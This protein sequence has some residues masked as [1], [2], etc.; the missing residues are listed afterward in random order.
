MCVGLVVIA[1][2]GLLAFVLFVVARAL[3]A[4]ALR[5]G[6]RSRP[7][8]EPALAS[9]AAAGWGRRILV[10]L[11][12]PLTVSGFATALC[13]MGMLVE[14]KAQI[15]GVIL[16]DGA[17]PGSPAEQAGLRRNDRIVGIDGA[18]PQ[19]YGDV[20]A[21]VRAHP[22]RPVDL[23]IERAGKRMRVAVQAGAA[24]TRFAGRIGVT[25]MPEFRPM[26]L[27]EAARSGLA[28]PIEVW[29]DT[30]E[31]ALAPPER[32]R[33]DLRGPIGIVEATKHTAG[34]ISGR[35]LTAKGMKLSTDTVPTVLLASLAMLL[36]GGRRRE[37]PPTTAPVPADASAAPRP[38]VRFVARTLDSLV[39]LLVAGVGAEAMGTSVP[40]L[41]MP[42]LLIPFEALLLSTWG[43]TPGKWLLRVAVR[44]A[45]GRRLSFR[46][47][48]HR[49]G[50]V[51]VFCLGGASEA[52]LITPIVSYRHLKRDGA[53]YWDKL[54]NF[55]VWHG[56][57]GAVRT[58]VAAVAIGALSTI[59]VAVT[60]RP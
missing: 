51:T 26:R 48:L 60:L 16:I 36:V 19:S 32:T 12:G 4:S 15:P 34:L 38:V 59:A 29:A 2:G 14:G 3:A 53:T 28:M 49:T 52:G 8:G 25:L 54:G 37:T 57:V 58:V 55:R 17:P 31:Q 9:F 6:D 46:E 10:T 13:V 41:V 45:D 24:G 47:A 44:D 20:G 23:E 5:I 43:Y 11:A 21:A 33:A 22:D 39:L 35:M 56:R 18:V 50:A 7:F 40:L 27:D 42:L 30:I 1:V